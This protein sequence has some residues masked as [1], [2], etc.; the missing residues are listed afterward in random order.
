[1]SM[2]VPAMTQAIIVPSTPVT[3]PN[4]AGNAKIPEPT[5]DPITSAVSALRDSFGSA[6]F[7]EAAMTKDG[8]PIGDEADAR[9]IRCRTRVTPGRRA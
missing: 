2:P 9:L 5:I 7:D 8:L 4:E 3:R 6:W 1:M